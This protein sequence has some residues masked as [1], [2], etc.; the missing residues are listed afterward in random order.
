[1]Y[2]CSF[3]SVLDLFQRRPRQ[4]RPTYEEIKT[5]VLEAGRY[6]V[7]EATYNNASVAFFERLGRDP[8]VVCTPVGF[9]WIRVE[10]KA[11]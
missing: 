3:D 4:K 10:R 5:R 1:M 9:P 8:E 11:P 7:F 2:V 6:S